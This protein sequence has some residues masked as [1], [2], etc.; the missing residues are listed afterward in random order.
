[1]FGFWSHVNLEKFQL[2]LAQNI[3]IPDCKQTL[4]IG[5]LRGIV[6]GGAIWGFTFLKKRDSCFFSIF[7][8]YSED[9]DSWT[10]E[11]PVSPT[12]DFHIL[13]SN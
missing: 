6:N 10:Q 12:L 1:M 11:I 3:Q 13:Y 9:V 2:Q 7:V 8:F 4:S 5:H